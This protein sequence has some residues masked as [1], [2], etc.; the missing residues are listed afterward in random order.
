MNSI[1]LKGTTLQF[2]GAYLE[3]VCDLVEDD[4]VL[5]LYYLS[6]IWKYRNDFY[7]KIKTPKLVSLFL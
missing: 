1:L 6:E 4:T 2:V 7:S 5:I 3:P